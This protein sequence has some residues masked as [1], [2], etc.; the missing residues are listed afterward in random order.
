MLV[1]MDVGTYADQSRDP[2]LDRI[3]ALCIRTDNTHSTLI[4]TIDD[5]GTLATNM[6]GRYV[7]CH[8]D[9]F[10]PPPPLALL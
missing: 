6:R 10:P 4:D 8:V 5:I 7:V 2:L 1:K 9:L 3:R